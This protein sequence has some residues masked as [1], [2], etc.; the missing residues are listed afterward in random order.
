MHGEEVVVYERPRPLK[1]A[2]R[3]LSPERHQVRVPEERAVGVHGATLELA[4]C[5]GRHQD[6]L[7]ALRVDR[8]LLRAVACHKLILQHALGALVVE[9]AAAGD[10]VDGGDALLVCAQYGALAGLLVV[11]AWHVCLVVGVGPLVFLP[12]GLHITLATT[13]CKCTRVGVRATILSK[14]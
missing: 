9:G 7:G 10:A 6:R 5:G 8:A 2:S 11:H 4:R 12:A 13:I 1:L 14:S 3:L